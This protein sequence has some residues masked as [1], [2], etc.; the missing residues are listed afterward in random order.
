MFRRYLILILAFIILNFNCVKGSDIEISNK[1]AVLVKEDSIN[2]YDL[3]NNKEILIDTK[4]DFK[5]PIISQ[6]GKAVAYIKD[7]DLYIAY[8]DK[9]PF[10]IIKV[11]IEGSYN[12]YNPNLLL[13]STANGGINL[14]NLETKQ[15]KVLLKDDNVYKNF[16]IDKNNNIYAE[17]YFY[18][19]QNSIENL[20]VIKYNLS[21][22]SQNTVIDAIPMSNDDY[23]FIPQIAC[24]SKDKSYIY[25]Y[26]LF[27]G[28]SLSKDGVPIGIYDINNQA[29]NQIDNLL[30]IPNNSIAVNPIDNTKFVVNS[31]SGRDLNSNKTITLIDSTKKSADYI[32]PNEMLPNQENKKVATN[33]NEIATMTPSFT[34]DGRALLYAASPAIEWS[35]TDGYLWYKNNHPIYS[36]NLVNKEIKRISYSN[37]TT[38]D[39][40]PKSISNDEI[41]FMRINEFNENTTASLWK[42]KNSSETL[43]V[44]DIKFVSFDSSTVF[45][46]YN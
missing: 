24:I 44:E 16:V 10:E 32:L 45:D 2:L 1:F 13:Y 8:L 34:L 5:S 27:E 42:T 9:A 4:G 12:W 17:K 29:F 15:N 25:I 37:S 38:F 6:A 31:G 28:N 30:S 46:I 39:F 7:K 33:L 35:K 40:A 41:I 18:F 3:I 20:G 19:G 26:C 11:D 36:I 14:F 43:L 22:L 23:G 21:S